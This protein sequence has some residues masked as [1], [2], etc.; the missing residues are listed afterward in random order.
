MFELLSNVQ[1]VPIDQNSLA[2]VHRGM[3]KVRVSVGEHS[4]EPS[5]VYIITG[6]SSGNLESYIIFYMLEPG[7]HVVY[8]C[9]ENPYSLDRKE[10]VLEEAIVFVEEMGSI[11]E[12]V[13]WETMTP[14]QRSAW[15]E[16]EILYAAPVIAELEKLDETEALA[17]VDEIEGVEYVGIDDDEPEELADE[18]EIEAGEYEEIDEEEPEGFDEEDID[19]TESSGMKGVV[20]AEGDFD[21]L[22]KQAF[23]KPDVADKTKLNKSKRESVKIEEEFSVPEEPADVQDDEEM[24][25]EES[26]R[27]E[28]VEN[29][30]LDEEKE[31]PEEPEAVVQEVV[32]WSSEELALGNVEVP[33]GLNESF[34]PVKK[35]RMEVIRFLSR[36]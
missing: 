27:F 11:L 4:S 17:E 23:L 28:A 8:G 1:S 29:T 13:P 12:E 6:H 18:D 20:I 21:E 33:A 25:E 7:I 3:N 34:L 26:E 16:K 22:L 30:E 15:V 14:D 2:M 31:I 19:G 36:F 35:N 32:E 24:V 10:E 5:E 9:D